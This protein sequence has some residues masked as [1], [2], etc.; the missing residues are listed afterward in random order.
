M[1]ITVLNIVIRRGWEEG[2]SSVLL[3]QIS[4]YGPADAWSYMYSKT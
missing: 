2:K 4:F 3:L 1:E